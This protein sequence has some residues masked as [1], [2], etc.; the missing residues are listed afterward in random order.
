MIDILL[1][2][3]PNLK[4]TR[5]SGRVEVYQFATC[6]LEYCETDTSRH[7]FSTFFLVLFVHSDL[8]HIW[9]QSRFYRA[10]EVILGLPYDM[11]ID[12]WSFGC[13]LSELYTGTVLGGFI[14]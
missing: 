10:P 3:R 8:T 6:M 1:F 13:I 14:G 7:V 2:R 11:G 5:I 4:G 9:P 12:M